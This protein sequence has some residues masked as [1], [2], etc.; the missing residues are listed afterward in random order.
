MLS[1]FLPSPPLLGDPDF[2]SRRFYSAQQALSPPPVIEWF[3]EGLF[4]RPS[5]NLIVGNPGTKK[6]YLTL[7]LAVC[8]ALG[9]PWL[10]RQTQ[11]LPVMIVDEETGLP[12][13]WARLHGVLHAHHAPPE[14]PLHFASLGAYDLR[15]RKEAI[16]LTQEA[17]SLGAGLIIIDAL[18]DVLGG[19]DENSVPSIQPVLLNLRWLSEA[20]QAAVIVIHHTNKSGIFRGSSSISAAV[21]LMLAVRSAAG[22]SLIHFEPLKART[23]M[24]L[25]FSAHAHFQNAAPG[26]P[27]RFWLTP[28][29]EQPAATP[30]RGLGLAATAI[31]NYVAANND[32]TTSQLMTQLDAGAPATIRSV[33]YQLTTSGLLTRSDDGPRGKT[34]QY[35][36]SDKGRA[37]LQTVKEL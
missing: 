9:K 5:L 23:S 10:G 24:P 2:S 29:D 27:E 20:A 7:D 16:Y 34:A 35:R 13:L 3:V 30:A 22:S 31:L 36:L 1:D 19:G 12:R 28:T 33:L 21:D 18:V 6:T 17:Q 4:T 25:P 26:I 11:P 8:V 14:T 32:A 37:Y 15:Q